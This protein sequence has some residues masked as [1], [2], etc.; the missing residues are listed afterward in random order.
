MLPRKSRLPSK[1][2][3]QGFHK[4]FSSPL[5]L[6]KARA[7]TVGRNRF[8][9]IIANRAI[10]KSTSRHSLKR[11]LSSRLG[12]IPEKGTDFIIIASPRINATSPKELDSELGEAFG[13][14]KKNNGTT[15]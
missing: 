10:P 6:L 3:G 4:V 12:K 13:L 1:E 15:I 9:V 7:N 5:F 11:F 14:F 8:A 2:M